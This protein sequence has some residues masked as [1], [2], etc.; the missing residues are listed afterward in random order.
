MKTELQKQFEEQTPT[1]KGVTD[2]EYLQTFISWLHLQV[3]KRDAIIGNLQPNQ[4]SDK[5]EPG[6]DTY[7]EVWCVITYGDTEIYKVY[8]DKDE[9][10]KVAYESNESRKKLTFYNPKYPGPEVKS[11]YDAIDIIKEAI[12]AR[13]SLP[14][15]LPDEEEIRFILREYREWVKN[16]SPY[17]E[18]YYK[19]SEEGIE[20]AMGVILKKL[21]RQAWESLFI[22][23]QQ[24]SFILLGRCAS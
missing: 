15:S 22:K 5:K 6:L 1:I 2:K 23:M 3:E 21:K 20:K 10:I 14:G 8:L 24:V 9:A 13:S 18:G 7:K 11:L 19:N 17:L 16:L 4:E 12:K